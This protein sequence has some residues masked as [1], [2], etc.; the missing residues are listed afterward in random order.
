MLVAKEE[1]VDEGR[2]EDDMEG[3]GATLVSVVDWD[4]C[5]FCNSWDATARS[6]SKLVS[7]AFDHLLFPVD[8]FAPVAV[9]V[10]VG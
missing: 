8:A 6:L 2:L 5:A 10:A 7:I 1:E 3:E 9:V 4:S